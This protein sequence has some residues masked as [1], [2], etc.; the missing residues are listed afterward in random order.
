M[1][2]EVSVAQGNNRLDTVSERRAKRLLTRV[3]NGESL[4]AA[5]NAER[6]RVSELKDPDSPVRR[7]LEQLMGQ[8]FLPPK[9]RAQMV[10][11]G[12][13]KV[14]LENIQSEDLAAQKLALDAAKQIAADPET[15]LTSQ[16]AGGVVINIGELAG[17]FSQ[18]R[19]SRIEEVDYGRGSREDR[20]VEVEFEHLPIGGG[21]SA[22]NPALPRGS[23]LGEPAEDV[24]A[25]GG[26][27]VPVAGR[28]GDGDEEGAGGGD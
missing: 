25:G 17:V 1:E 3:K 23:E 26:A 10:R 13:N 7:S 4:S 2:T 14:F 8:Y 16:D 15:G 21:E 19:E 5:A 18:I 28:P 12:L 27:D 11:A 9:A 22:S 6:M 20:G 24:S